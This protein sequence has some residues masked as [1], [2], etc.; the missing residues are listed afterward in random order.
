MKM[1]R[2]ISW[3]WIA[4]SAVGLIIISVMVL[5]L[6]KVKYI[7]FIYDI[8]ITLGSSLGVFWCFYAIRFCFTKTKYAFVISNPEDYKG[9][10]LS[11]ISYMSWIWLVLFPILAA[12]AIPIVYIIIV[13]PLVNEKSMLWAR[14]GVIV[15]CIAIVSLN[16]LS[17]IY[18]I[19]RLQHELIQGFELKNKG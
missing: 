10:F 16:N 3:L 18:V 8:L 7:D 2:N 11:S 6:I 1:R 19:K 15:A 5:T 17:Y 12:A 14:A 4:I 9:H 13:F